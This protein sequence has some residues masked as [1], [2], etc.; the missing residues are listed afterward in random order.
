MH[1]HAYSIIHSIPL[2]YS[3]SLVHY[4]FHSFFTVSGPVQNL[5]VTA[6]N[7]TALHITW[8]EPS[9]TNGANIYTIYVKKYTTTPYDKTFYNELSKRE[10][11]VN[12]LSE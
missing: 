8:D 1:I 3:I 6:I 4:N 2:H 5:L 7:S 11:I 9:I 12:G 10:Q